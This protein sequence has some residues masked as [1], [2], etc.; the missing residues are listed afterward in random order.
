MPTLRVPGG[1][2]VSWG[3]RSNSQVKITAVVPFKTSVDGPDQPVQFTLRLPRAVLRDFK[4]GRGALR[5]LGGTIV[6]ALPRLRRRGKPVKLRGDAHT[7]VEFARTAIPIL[8]SVVAWYGP[9]GG[10]FLGNVL[11]SHVRADFVGQLVATTPRGAVSACARRLTLA[12]PAAFAGTHPLVVLAQRDTD[13]RSR[14]VEILSEDAGIGAYLEAVQE[15]GWNIQQATVVALVDRAFRGAWEAAGHPGVI[16]AA[17][18][19]VAALRHARLP[20]PPAIRYRDPRDV[21]REYRSRE[22][23]KRLADGFRELHLPDQ[24]ANTLGVQSVIWPSLVAALKSNYLG[25][26]GAAARRFR[27]SVS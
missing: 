1:P 8:R 3:G 27:L 25:E 17:S 7:S 10:Q 15:N 5:G 6:A 13:L 16:Y 4:K 9:D 2:T 18:A 20:I 23:D 26:P 24:H 11:D 21:C 19:D 12:L 22:A 14:I